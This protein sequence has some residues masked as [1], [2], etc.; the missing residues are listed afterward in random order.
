MKIRIIKGRTSDELAIRRLDG[1]ELR[2]DFP[3]KGPVP[4]DAVHFFVEQALGL[5]NGFWGMVASGRHPDEIGALVAA[6]GHRSASRC[7]AP[8]P[9]FLEVIQAE[10]LVECFEADLWGGGGSDDDLRAM[11]VS[12]CELSCVPVPDLPEPAIARARADLQALLASWPSAA[13]GHQLVLHW[14]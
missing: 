8:D 2:A 7:E 5:S 3:H 1:T 6:A 11:A 4:H 9:S 14:R 13:T 12:G 10:R